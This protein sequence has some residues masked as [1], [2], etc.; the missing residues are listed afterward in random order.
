MGGDGDHSYAH[1]ARAQ[2][3][4]SLL[5]VSVSGG[6]LDARRI[7]RLPPAFVSKQVFII[8]FFRTYK[9]TAE[10]FYT[11]EV[12]GGGMNS[13]KFMKIMETTMED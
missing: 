8:V 11:D 2:R 12:Q 1:G 13:Q 10:L 6:A 5:L 9:R 4:P 3:A 7:S